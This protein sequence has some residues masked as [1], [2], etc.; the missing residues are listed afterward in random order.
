MGI[1][2]LC[3]FLNRFNQE[4]KIPFE[5]AGVR[6]V[7]LN[8]YSGKIIAIDI[9]NLAHKNKGDEEHNIK[10]ISKICYK[11]LKHKIFPLFVFD[12]RMK[13]NK[14]TENLPQ[15]MIEERKK[16]EEEYQQMMQQLT[17]DK[18]KTVSKRYNLR[19]KNKNYTVL[20]T[21]IYELRNTTEDLSFEYFQRMIQQ[22]ID[23]I[24]MTTEEIS[25]QI[26]EEEINYDYFHSCNLSDIIE[27]KE[28]SEKL[29]TTIVNKDIYYFKSLLDFYGIAY[30]EAYGEADGMLSQL[31]NEGI[32]DAVIS[33]DS[34]LLAFGCNKLLRNFDVYKDEI[35]EYRIEYILDNLGLSYSQFLDMCILM[36]TDF[37]ERLRRSPEVIY[38]MILEKHDMDSII[39]SI[40]KLPGNFKDC[41]EKTRNIFY[42]RTPKYY[43]DYTKGIMN[44]SH[45]D[46]DDLVK[47]IN[48]TFMN[49]KRIVKMQKESK[50]TN[51]VDYLSLDI[52]SSE[53]SDSEPEVPRRRMIRRPIEN[54]VEKPIKLKRKETDSIYSNNYSILCLSDEE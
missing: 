35:L 14:F 32:I 39:E 11:L 41:C 2:G 16:Y 20:Y 46:E 15:L 25:Q 52:S 30:V 12:S 1:Q 21:K 18:K 31:C 54:P 33:D 49:I 19:K 44:V 45:E 6:T 38:N 37:N 53:S 22:Y 10:I 50:L 9:S 23:E 8:D 42:T 48:L 51:F 17:E 47:T 4:N 5:D 24:N 13:K 27:K 3:G 26:K 29:S 43:I 36:G 40:P 7:D 34:D 28:V